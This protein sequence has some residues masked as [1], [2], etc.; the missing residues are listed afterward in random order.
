LEFLILL[1]FLCITFLAV[2]QETE[3]HHG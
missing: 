3:F 2:C 1:H